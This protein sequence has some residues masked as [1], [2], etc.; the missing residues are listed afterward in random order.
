MQDRPPRVTVLASSRHVQMSR[1]AWIRISC[2]SNFHTRSSGRGAAKHQHTHGRTCSQ[3][4]SCAEGAAAAAAGPAGAQGLQVW[5]WGCCRQ[6]QLPWLPASRRPY[7]HI[8][9]QR[10][11]ASCCSFEQATAHSSW[12]ELRHRQLLQARLRASSQQQTHPGHSSADLAG[13]APT[14]MM[15]A[16][17]T[18]T[19]AKA[20]LQAID[21][22]LCSCTS[23]AFSFSCAA[24]EEIPG[25]SIE[26]GAAT[27]KSCPLPKPTGG[28]CSCQLSC[29]QLA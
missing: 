12:P 21:A 28:T 9:P 14:A 15:T 8:R 5:C 1:C 13:D 20:T 10:H 16:C 6:V 24:A 7:L 22:L 18:P 26:P 23:L 27:F 2:Q 17:T 29:M 25:A 11:G 3:R 19:I 4:P